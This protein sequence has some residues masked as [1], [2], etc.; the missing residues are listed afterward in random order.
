MVPAKPR[1]PAKKPVAKKAAAADED[2][3]ESV[4]PPKRGP[5]AR[6]AGKTGAAAS[7]GP[8]KVVKAED[9]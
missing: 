8:A 7:S 3:L 5:P 4:G 1:P 2:E 6:L 9:I